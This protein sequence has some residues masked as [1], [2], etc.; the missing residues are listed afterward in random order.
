M[1]LAHA[2]PPTGDV[3]CDKA[4]GARPAVNEYAI[5]PAVHATAVNENQH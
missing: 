2:A 3:A 4:C 5:K 1:P